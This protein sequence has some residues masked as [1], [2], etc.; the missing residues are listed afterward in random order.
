M[1]GGVGYFVSGIGIWTLFIWALISSGFGFNWWGYL[2]GI[3]VLLAATIL[4][5]RGI[6][7]VR[8]A[9]KWNKVKNK[10]NIVKLPFFKP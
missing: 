10:R 3:L 7:L 9:I 6:N 4:A 1:I 2:I 8:Y 5:I